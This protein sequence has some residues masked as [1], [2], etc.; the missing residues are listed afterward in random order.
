[1][2]LCGDD[3]QRVRVID[4]L[5]EQLQQAKQDVLLST[6]GAGGDCFPQ[7]QQRVSDSS[8]SHGT[9]VSPGS[10][11]S[12]DSS[13]RHL[14]ANHHIGH[15]HHYSRKHGLE[16]GDNNGSS[17]V[18]GVTTV[19]LELPSQKHQQLPQYNRSSSMMDQQRVDERSSGFKKVKI[20]VT[21]VDMKQN[22]LQVPR[23]FI[24]Y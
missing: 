24:F 1:M 9:H 6:G 4:T 13:G 14:Q 17:R 16:H 10:Q 2:R 8:S 7:Q 20:D 15:H 19:Q 22:Q 3:Q 11:T 12:D 5:I 23:C 18:S 21:D